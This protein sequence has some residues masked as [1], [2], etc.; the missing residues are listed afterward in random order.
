MIRAITDFLKQENDHAR[1]MGRLDWATSG[2]RSIVGMSWRYASRI[3]LRCPW[4]GSRLERQG[5]AQIGGCSRTL[6]TCGPIC[7]VPRSCSRRTRRWSRRADATL[8]YQIYYCPFSC[9][10]KGSTTGGSS[11]IPLCEVSKEGEEAPIVAEPLC[12]FRLQNQAP[13][14]R[15]ICGTQEYLRAS[16]PSLF[17]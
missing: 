2:P 11:E 3:V 14:R 9:L 15:S 17:L 6:A 5:E 1:A 4:S 8:V 10:D 12:R 7:K 13:L 16:S